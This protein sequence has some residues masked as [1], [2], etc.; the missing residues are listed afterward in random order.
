MGRPPM[1]VKE[2]ILA[3][4]S[5]D[6]QTGC[7]EWLASATV[8]G[9][10]R[11]M[12]TREKKVHRSSL[13]HRAA[14]EE[15][16]GPIPEGLHI[17]HLCRNTICCNPEHLEAVTPLENLLRSEAPSNTFRTAT[18]CIHGHEFTPENTQLVPKGRRCI[19]CARRRARESA[20]R[21]KARA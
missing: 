18:H 10:G 21:K 11:I 19:A 9:Y 1:S 16:V 12:L 4:T 17:D 8:S 15:W 14:Y 6:P 20:Q 13:A 2:R 3:Y 5:V 7:W